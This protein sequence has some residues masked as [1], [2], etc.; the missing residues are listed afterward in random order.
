MG[1]NRRKPAAALSQC[2]TELQCSF[3]SLIY[4]IIPFNKSDFLYLW[5]EGVFAFLIQHEGLFVISFLHCLFAFSFRGRKYGDKFAEKLSSILP[6]FPTL[7]KL[8]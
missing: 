8:E 7:R 2:H 5:G 3:Y 4:S 1:H 6:K